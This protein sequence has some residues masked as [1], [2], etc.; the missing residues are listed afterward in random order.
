[1]SVF[2][3]YSTYY[4]LLYQDKNYPEEANYISGLIKKYHPQSKSVLDLGCGT[5]KHVAELAK[6]GYKVT[7]L[8]RSEEMLKE[9]NSQYPKIDFTLGDIRTFNIGQSFDVVT[10]LFHVISY[11]PKNSDQENTFKSIAKHVKKGGLFIFD[12]WYGPA[13]LN[14]KPTVR[15]KL[16][17]DEKNKVIRTVESELDSM[18]NL[19]KV[20]YKILVID[21]KTK[22]TQELQE[23]HIMRYVFTPEVERLLN[24][25]G[26]K[27]LDSHEWLTQ[28]KPSLE[29]WGVTFIAQKS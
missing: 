18:R 15:I 6:L 16:L 23:T 10:S 4:N 26:F 5:G 17:E 14:L 19:V 24:L 25:Y 13:V 3:A 7:G 12:A 11:L 21:K 27:L 28:K 29:T 8:D 22:K 2:G 1:M 9:A 20:N